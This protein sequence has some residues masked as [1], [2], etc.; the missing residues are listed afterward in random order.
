[1]LSERFRAVWWRLWTNSNPRGYWNGGRV[2][3]IDA[4]MLY[5]SRKR[6]SPL[7]RDS[8]GINRHGGVS[9]EGW[10]ISVGESPTRV[11]VRSPVAWIVRRKETESRKPIDE[12]IERM[13]SESSGRNE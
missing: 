13:V 10:R 8:V 12:A 6:A 1:M 4:A 2:T 7:C 11:K 5:T 9:S 3:T